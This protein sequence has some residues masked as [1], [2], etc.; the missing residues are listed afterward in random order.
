MTSTMILFLETQLEEKNGRGIEFVLCRK[1]DDK[2]PHIQEWLS[3][4][5]IKRWQFNYWARGMEKPFISVSDIYPVAGPLGKGTQHAA[6]YYERAVRNWTIWEGVYSK[7][8]IAYWTTLLEWL[9]DEKLQND[10]SN[11]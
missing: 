1:A 7:N 5:A 9:K 8:Y 11:V 6:V 2:S 3:E 4:F 10:W